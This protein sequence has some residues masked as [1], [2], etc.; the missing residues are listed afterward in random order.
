VDL[1]EIEERAAVV[2]RAVRPIA[3]RPWSSDGPEVDPLAE[4][5]MADEAPV[6]V[7]ALLDAY[8]S[9]PES[10]RA[11]VRAIFRKYPYF[12]WA[13]TESRPAPND[14]PAS[15]SKPASASKAAPESEPPPAGN[16]RSEGK[17]A[18]AGN[19]RSES[20]PP[21]AGNPGSESRP[22][23]AGS[24]RSESEPG[25]AGSRPPAEIFRRDLV[26]LSALDQGDDARDMIVAIDFLC[27]EAR[28]EGIDV[29]PIL[30]EVAEMSSTENR[31]G[32]GSSR[33]ILL[34]AS[35]AKGRH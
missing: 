5:G 22:D 10:E 12:S 13:A 3:T 2:D 21:P 6:L 11:K 17:P 7:G 25:A 27:R 33:E 24:S 23:T 19:P 4:A 32:M 15:E 18:T 8:E 14:K 28:A 29:D 30:R 9:S 26:H 16:P 34:R 31:M 35:G 1:S 20:E